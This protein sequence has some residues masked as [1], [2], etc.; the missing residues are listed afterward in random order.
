MI[1]MDQDLQELVI[2]NQQT[3]LELQKVIVYNLLGQQLREWEIDNPITEQRFSLK[4][5]ASNV[6][7][8]HVMTNQGKIVQK[9]IKE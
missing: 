5:E 3:T 6:Y 8:V 7:I 2:R 4:G 9:I 1:F